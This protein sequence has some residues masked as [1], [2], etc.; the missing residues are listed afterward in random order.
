M[1]I[2]NI[3]NSELK[4]KPVYRYGNIVF[5]NLENTHNVYGC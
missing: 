4:R 3:F 5:F 2:E 1:T